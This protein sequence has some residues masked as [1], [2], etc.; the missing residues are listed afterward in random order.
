V[1]V[2]ALVAGCS[3]F[4]AVNIHQDRAPLSLTGQMSDI[5]QAALRAVLLLL[6]SPAF[7]NSDPACIPLVSPILLCSSDTHAFV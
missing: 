5:Q 4:C 6:P 1:C 2:C 7:P 3:L